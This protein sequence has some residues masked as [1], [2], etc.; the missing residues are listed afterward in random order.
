MLQDLRY[1]VR[2]FAKTPGFTA[3]AVV[4]LAIGIGANQVVRRDREA[5]SGHDGEPLEIVGIAPGLRDTL[6]LAQNLEIQRTGG[7][8]PIRRSADRRHR[9]ISGFSDPPVCS[10][11][12]DISNFPWLHPPASRL[13]GLHRVLDR[14]SKHSPQRAFVENGL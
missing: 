4:V 3:L 13:A 10:K 14:S 9:S 6:L 12:L 8:E 11:I 2:T 1:A 5:G 7:L